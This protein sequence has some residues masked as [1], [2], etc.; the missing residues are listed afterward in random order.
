MAKRWQRDHHHHHQR[1][2]ALL[3]QYA[4]LD[5]E[6]RL[7]ALYRDVTELAETIPDKGRAARVLDRIADRLHHY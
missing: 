2:T 6:N 5:L 3:N 4:H 7:E 1:L